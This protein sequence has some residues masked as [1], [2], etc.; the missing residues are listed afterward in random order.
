MSGHPLQAHDGDGCMSG[1]MNVPVVACC[2]VFKSFIGLSAWMLIPLP[3]R[4]FA[5]ANGVDSGACY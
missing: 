2:H 5:D 3:A 4:L 1:N